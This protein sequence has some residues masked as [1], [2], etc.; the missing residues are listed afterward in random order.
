MSSGIAG[1][2][3]PAERPDALAEERAHVG[4]DEARVG[5]RLEKAG[6]TR[7]RTQ[8]VAVVEDDRA[9]LLE[10]HHRRALAGHRVA[11][12]A[13]VLLGIRFAE[14]ASLVG[15]V[16]GGD[17]AAERIVGRGLVGHDVR[18]DAAR[19]QLLEDLRRVADEADRATVALALRLLDLAQRRVEIGRHEVEVARLDATLEMLRVDVDDQADAV[20][21]RDREGLRAAHAATAGREHEP[22]AQRAAEVRARDRREGLVGALHD[23][24]GADVDPRAGGHL[25]VHREALGLE[26]PERVPVGPLGHEVRVRDQDARR[27]VVRAEDADRLARLHEQRLVVAEP[28]ERRHDRVERLPRAGRAPGAAVHDEAIGILGHVRVE[29]VHQHAERCFLLPASTGE[30]EAARGAHGAR[31]GGHRVR[32]VAPGRTRPRPFQ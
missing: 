19:E 23:A 30:L 1:E 3:R 25:P 12:L 7:L 13:D 11:R 10:A 14:L 4:L 5:E 22:T 2:R 17:V 32:T 31:A 15:R 24:L 9:E 6:R 27:E 28:P 8:A 16:P 18:H 26:A 21:H 20:V 29:V